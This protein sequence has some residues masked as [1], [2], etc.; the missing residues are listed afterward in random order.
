MA[1]F[2]ETPKGYYSRSQLGSQMRMGR[3]M[4]T[5]IHKAMV[6]GG[7]VSGSQTNPKPTAAAE[8]LYH[9]VTRANEDG[10]VAS[11]IVWHESLVDKLKPLVKHIR[12]NPT[13]T[14]PQP[15]R[16]YPE[17]YTSCVLLSQLVNIEGVTALHVIQK[18][19]DFGY[20]KDED[21]KLVPTSKDEF[22]TLWTETQKGKEVSWWLWSTGLAEDIADFF[23]A[24]PIVKE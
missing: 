18:L 23:R 22:S 15:A 21:G 19:K 3:I 24:N 10:T 7:Y 1:T 6:Q 13:S 11:W 8:G 9:T 4:W 2:T 5:V 14:G 17:G 16:S 12:E 20:A